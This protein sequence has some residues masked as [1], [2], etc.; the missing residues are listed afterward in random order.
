MARRRARVLVADGSEERGDLDFCLQRN[1]SATVQQASS[2][3]DVT[4]ISP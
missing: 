4:C 2:S 3:S 1:F